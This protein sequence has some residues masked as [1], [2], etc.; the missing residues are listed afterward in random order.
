MASK[1][2]FALSNAIGIWQDG[3]DL[4]VSRFDRYP[5]LAD[6]GA[7]RI[8]PHD[9]EAVETRSSPSMQTLSSQRSYSGNLSLHD[10]R[11]QLSRG[12]RSLDGSYGDRKL[13]RKHAALNLHHQGQGMG[14]GLC[15]RRGTI[16]VS[17]SSAASS[18]PPLSPSYSMSAVSQPSE[19]DVDTFACEL[20]P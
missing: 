5:D 19:M 11:R 7:E 3:H 6:P 4:D 2:S 20:I 15:A 8:Y 13:R 1:H 9:L 16:S 14:M 18:P 10:Y 17:A 12:S